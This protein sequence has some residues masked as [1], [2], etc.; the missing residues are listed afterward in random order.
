[1]IFSSGFIIDCHTYLQQELLTFQ[2]TISVMLLYFI[3]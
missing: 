3:N 1:M 2:Y